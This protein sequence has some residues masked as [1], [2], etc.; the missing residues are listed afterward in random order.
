MTVSL[1]LIN[2][3]CQASSSVALYCVPCTSSG[4]NC[5][6]T[7]PIQ[8]L[9]ETYCVFPKI[10]ADGQSQPPHYAFMLWETNKQKRVIA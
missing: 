8:N 1:K 10:W 6:C 4:S 7:S 3:L 9:R 2:H 5:E